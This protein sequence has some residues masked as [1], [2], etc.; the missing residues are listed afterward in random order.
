M[1]ANPGDFRFQ[2]I[3]GRGRQQLSRD[4]R[5]G[6]AA[7]VFIEDRDGGS[8]GYTFDLMWGGY[9]YPGRGPSSDYRGPGDR[10]PYGS[11]PGPATGPGRRF[12]TEQAVAVCQ[13]AVRDRVRD[14]FR[15]RR[16][17][18]LNT[19][20][21]DNPGRNDWVIGALEVYRGRNIED[22]YRFSCSVDFT[23]GRVRSAEVE[24]RGM[25][26]D[27]RGDSDRINT[28]GPNRAIRNCQTAAEARV[29]R[30]G[31]DRVEVANIR[32]DDA[33]GRNDW[34][35]GNMRAFGRRGSDTFAFSCSVDLRDGDVRNVDVTRR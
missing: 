3:D 6:G 30:D 35:V 27:W 12:T 5:Q 25:G 22:R 19:R 1:P 7:V 24:P 28:G 15:G 21:D 11:G 33:P 23:T 26:R 17:E 31:Y 16:V 20:I 13:D 32:M 18:F 2:G 8:E 4:P 29:I 34:V 10:G 14:R 9:Q